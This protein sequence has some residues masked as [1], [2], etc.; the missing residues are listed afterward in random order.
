VRAV[1]INTPNNGSI[2]TFRNI[3]VRKQGFII[4]GTCPKIYS[5][6][7]VFFNGV[8]VT[9]NGSPTLGDNIF[10]QTLT[11][12]GVNQTNF[13][14]APTFNQNVTFG[15]G[16]NTGS[17]L[18]FLGNVTF[19]N[20]GTLLSLGNNV[21]AEFKGQNLLRD[22][23][24]GTNCFIIF[25]DNDNT[26]DN[27]TLNSYTSVRF[28]QNK[29]TTFNQNLNAS[30]ACDTWISLGSSVN[31]IAANLNFINPQTW[32]GVIVK[33][34]NNV[35]VTATANNSS[36][37]GNNTN[38]NFVA[39]NPPRTLYWMGGASGDWSDGSKWS[40]DAM[41]PR[42]PANC[43]PTPNDDVVFDDISF[44]VGGGTVSMN[45]FLMFCKDMTWNNTNR[46]G[47]LSGL[48]NT[49]LVFGNMTLNGARTVN[50]F[51]GEVEFRGTSTPTTK[52]ITTNG[53]PFFGNVIFFNNDTWIL[54][55][56]FDINNSASLTLNYG[57]VDMNNQNVNV[58]GNFLINA[59]ATGAGL[60]QA[61]FITG[62][63]TITFDGK[64]NTQS[65]R[66]PELAAGSCVACDC[67]T[68][69]FYNLVINKSTTAN[70]KRLNLETGISIKNNF[71]I[72]DGDV[73]DNG[74][75][76][77]GNP[78]GTFTMANNTA[79]RLGG[80]L[81]SS[82]FPTCFTN[83]SISSGTTPGLVNSELNTVN[84]PATNPAI[85]DYRSSRNQLVKNTTYGTLLFTATSTNFRTRQLQGPITVNGS[86]IVNGGIFLKDMG[87]Q[88]TGNSFAGNRI[89]VNGGL[90]LGTSS[91]AS[92]AINTLDFPP[93]PADYTELTTDELVPPAPSAFPVGVPLPPPVALN[94]STVFPTFAPIGDYVIGAG[95]MQITGSISYTSGAALQNVQTGFTYANLYAYGRNLI[96]V[97][98][99]VGTAGN[100]LKTTGNFLVGTEVTFKDKGFQIDATGNL[101]LF[102]SSVLWI[103]EGTK[104]TKF[105]PNLPLTG[106]V[107]YA[108]CL[109]RY[110]ADVPQEVS[111]RPVY[112]GLWLTAP[113]VTS[114]S[115]VS[116]TFVP[117]APVQ[118][119]DF[120]LIGAY[121]NLIDNGSQIYSPPN[122]K[123]FL[124][125]SNSVLTLGNS[126]IATS[127]PTN[128]DYILAQTSTVV[129]NS[130]QLQ[131]VDALNGSC[132]PISGIYAQN[133]FG[134]LT[135]ASNLPMPAAVKELIGAIKVNNNL[136]I[137]S[138][139]TL[140]DMGFQINGSNL[141]GIMTME[142][143]STLIL[144]NAV[145]A[146]AYPTFYQRN[147]NF[148]DPGSTVIYNADPNQS[149]TTRPIYGG[150]ILRKTTV[151]APFS[152]KSLFFPNGDRLRITGD[153]II[154]SF[155]EF[156]DNGVLTTWQGTSNKTLTMQNNTLMTLGSSNG[157]TT[158]PNQF[159]TIDLSP[160][161]N[162]S[163]TVVYNSTLAGNN[164]AG[165]N[166]A[167][168]PFSYGNLTL[169]S[170]GVAVTKNQLSSIDVR[171]NLTIN[172]N[173]TL[174]ATTS[175]FNINLGGNWTNTGGFFTARGG[176]VTLDGAINQN[177]ST[178]TSDF[179]SLE[180]TNPQGATML[181]NIG[182][183]GAVTFTNG[184]FNPSTNQIFIFRNNATVTPTPG[185]FPGAP[186]PSN[187]SFING[188]VRKIGNQAFIF[189]VGKV[190]D[191][192][193]RW[194]A[195]IGIS[196][197]ANTTTQFTATYFPQ[198]PNP[199]Y[200]RSITDETFGR[201]SAVEYWTL[202][203]AV[204]N[205]NVRVLLSWDTPRSG[206]VFAPGA[207]I[208]A[209]WRTAA[210]IWWENGGNSGF[211]GNYLQGTLT[212]SVV[213]NNFSPFTLGSTIPNNPLPVELINF[214]ATP[215]YLAKNVE[216]RWQ[217]AS[218]RSNE[219]FTLEKSRNGVD[220]RPFAA[221]PSKAK[222][223]NS[224]EILSYQDIDNE[225]FSGL[226]Y[227][228]LKQ[229][230][231]DGTSKYSKMVAV[232]FETVEE[233]DR[234]V[235]Y[236]NPTEGAVLN[237]Q[238]LDNTI[239]KAE[240]SIQDVLGKAVYQQ[241]VSN[242]G[243][244]L[245]QIRFQEKLSAG[246][247]LIKIISNDKVYIKK[248]NVL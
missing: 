186:G 154:E 159:A 132:C 226:S 240:I 104:A 117:T 39:L 148:L 198:D 242:D 81:I 2:I 8:G 11:F 119:G 3:E 220:F 155:N 188:T 232:R 123:Q 136:L 59:P 56:A 166:T 180:I 27:M 89:F 74:F 68:S 64:N 18:A 237:I 138:N 209:H 182:A 79:L 211:T 40:F 181:T 47:T 207:L 41:A 106:I 126:A 71:T 31:G 94:T 178:N 230:D 122:Y 184:L 224:N 222:N 191:A 20:A 6:T 52:T 218:E 175:N 58:E 38:I 44:P 133:G 62:T 168:V 30:V 103:G 124:M 83:I 15:D 92:T 223:G 183:G 108:G 70:G 51:S 187:N 125:E 48:F 177:L 28:P 113:G 244:D 164:I 238:F 50:N 23:T 25:D 5:G 101:F 102:P 221:I 189:P 172:A 17:R 203:R 77:R 107:L 234:F 116:K 212:S 202:D 36:S 76:I 1:T 144:G 13:N 145:S 128:F 14:C 63:N 245:L 105:P 204:N 150:L 61:T 227:Y 112:Q 215:N 21:N 213:F 147:F 19:P 135:I 162:P 131:K 10:N 4:N 217:T 200:N 97:K 231:T 243:T 197:P 142:D 72:L 196:A 60:P 115:P 149:I 109:V 236:P 98:E 73:W 208:V 192:S 143:R 95:K 201:V 169:N 195:P 80:T 65:I 130:N 35:G 45:L 110:N 205:D 33:D 228:R 239:Q 118:L 67:N 82:V 157:S 210:P 216:L 91:P 233:E 127:M 156:R 88:I 12:Q 87:F 229:T 246:S 84:P 99:L 57:I 139:N 43:V 55:D 176:K 199:L 160:N 247:Y 111:T 141:N 173:N 26:I 29:L 100:Q 179:F 194:Y 9:I 46:T 165:T 32:L 161:A 93:S 121:N 140:N 69:S 241:R 49:L 137:K 170:G 96:S 206:G 34:I 248:F 85:I 16:I 7:L 146:T 120:S 22:I 134:N 235:V 53:T 54:Q 86:L 78:T 219:F 75:Q 225:P 193:T 158:F 185:T 24:T 163:S 190:I 114:G 174:D 214:T 129:Y 153:F 167:N 90:S 37:G 42:T 152:V 66:I 151:S 171:K